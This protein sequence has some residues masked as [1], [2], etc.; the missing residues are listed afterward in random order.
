VCKFEGGRFTLTCQGQ[1]VFA[2]KNQLAEILGLKPG[3]VKGLTPSVGGSFGRKGSIYPEYVCLAHAARAL[4]RPVKWT[5]ERSGSFLSDQHGR[6]HEM[7]ATLALNAEGRF[8]G[9][10][11]EGHGNVGA[12]VGTVAPQPPTMNVV[13]NVTSVY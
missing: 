12:Y 13:R 4:G 2:Q 10:K 5:D 1:G 11:I 7:T 3:E 6:D 8:L 9:L